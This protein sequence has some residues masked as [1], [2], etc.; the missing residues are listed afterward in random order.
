MNLKY[1]HL[2]FIALSVVLA[3]YV[4]A[5]G[6][7]NGS[8]LAACLSVASAIVLVAYGTTFQRKMRRL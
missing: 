8:T 4:A 1:F 7:N 6:V 3:A 2:F 5:W